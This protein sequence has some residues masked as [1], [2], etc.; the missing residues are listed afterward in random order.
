MI[1]KMQPFVFLSKSIKNAGFLSGEK[2]GKILL[3]IL[4]PFFFWTDIIKMKRSVYKR[5]RD[6]L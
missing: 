1:Q 4:E 5:E 2:T 6:V 3:G